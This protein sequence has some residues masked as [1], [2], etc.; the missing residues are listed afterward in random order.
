VRSRSISKPRSIRAGIVTPTP[1]A[2]DS[3]ADPVVWT[4][5]FSRIELRRVRVMAEK[6]RKSE[7]E[8]TAI[9]IDAETV[10]PT[11]RTRYIDDAE[12]M[13][14]STAPARTAD[15]VNSGIVLFEGGT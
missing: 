3:P 6:P 2:I 1:K 9:G 5:L 7:I 11:L 10:M 8:S 13:M 4:M 15:Q 12:K 14:P